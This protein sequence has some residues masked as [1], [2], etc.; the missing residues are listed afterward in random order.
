MNILSLLAAALVLLTPGLAAQSLPAAPAP[1]GAGASLLT[2]AECRAL[3]LRQNQRLTVA[4]RRQQAAEAAQAAAKTGRLPK[5]DASSTG[6]YVRGL[7]GTPLEAQGV[8]TGVGMSQPIYSGG[9]IRSQIALAGLQAEVSGEDVRAARQQLVAETDQTYWQAIAL[10]EQVGLAE[11]NRLQLQALVR[12]LDHKYQ[13]GLVYKADLLRAQVQLRDADVQLLRARDEQQLSQQV[14]RQLIG[15]PAGDSLRLADTLEGE[16]L[17]VAAADYQARAQVQRPDL[18]QLALNTRADS[19][20]IALARS[21]RR[22]QVN[23]SA[24]A[25]LLVQRPN[26]FLPDRT[27]TPAYALVSVNLPLV[28]WKEHRLLEAQRRYQAQANAAQL[29]EA[30]QQVQLEISRDL[31]RLNQAVR[32]IELQRLTVAQAAENLRLNDNR[33]RA[34]LLS[35]VD[36]LQAQT[37]SQQAAAALVEAQAEYRMAE[38]ALARATGEQD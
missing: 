38:A 12:D 29:T 36:L 15:W 25:L 33:F 1:A 5:L 31:L 6:Y 2:L 30:R 17:P 13:A 8:A 34:G 23:A 4:A 28:H 10:R 11:R 26:V 27:L 35:L 20:L 21:A 32:R 22:P 7:R 9:R 18:R 37:V 16:F 3:A 14:L 19:L 24:N